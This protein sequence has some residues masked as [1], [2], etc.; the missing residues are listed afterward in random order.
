MIK[1]FL[2]YKV[3]T[4]HRHA[5]ILLFLFDD[6]GEFKV[7]L[8]DLLRGSKPAGVNLLGSLVFLELFD[9]IES[10][11]VHLDDR[12]GCNE[13]V[14]LPDDLLLIPVEGAYHIGG[15]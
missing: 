1:E 12:V 11:F 7:R 2:G 3:S 9:L 13:V 8:V 10:F 15:L 6:A 5:S 4:V 14:L